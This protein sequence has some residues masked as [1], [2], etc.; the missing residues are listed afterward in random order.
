MLACIGIVLVFHESSRLAGAYGIAV[1]ATMGITSILYFF[2]ITKTWGWSLTQ[3][4]PLV[5]LFIIFDVAFMG[6]N[7]F[8]IVDGGWF[9]LAVA[10]VIMIA[11]TTWRDGRAELARKMIA[12]R[13]PINLFIKDI[14]T[15]KTPRIYGS[16]VFMT[17]SPVG[18]PSALLHHFKH[19]HVLH[20]K[21]ILLTVRFMD[22]PVVTA[23]ERLKV[24]KLEAGFYRVVAFFGF[25]EHPRIPKVLA[26][27]R[28]FGLTI[29]PSTTTYFLGRESLTT[30]GHSKMMKWRKVLFVFMSR[31]A[32]TAPSYFGIP[33]DRVIEMGVQIEL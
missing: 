21:V 5:A 30:T 19:N 9:T 26:K 14:T 33:A 2:V 4:I 16:A 15:K 27:A 31:N 25:M 28:R 3:A 1:T 20:E 18:T 17:V 22:V 23:A 32:W 7:L 12:T 10:L 6:A 11:M 8:K 13:F 24:E 29:D